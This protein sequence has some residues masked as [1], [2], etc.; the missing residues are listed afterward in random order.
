MPLLC[1]L[2]L[3]ND[4]DCLSRYNLAPEEF[5]CNQGIT[6]QL[7]LRV[8][9]LFVPPFSSPPVTPPTPHL[10]PHP[11]TCTHSSRS[12]SVVNAVTGG[13]W[14]VGG[15]AAGCGFQMPPGQ[16]N[17]AIR[18]RFAQD[19]D[20]TVAFDLALDSIH[21][22]V[23][24]QRDSWDFIHLDAY[25]HD[26][27]LVS[28]SLGVALYC[29]VLPTPQEA[30][31]VVFELVNVTRD[32]GRRRDVN[33]V[34]KGSLVHTSTPFVV[35]PMLLVRTPHIAWCGMELE[36]S[37]SQ[38]ALS[39]C[40]P[41]G[42]AFHL[43][44]AGKSL[45]RG[46]LG[47]FCRNSLLFVLWCVHGCPLNE[48]MPQGIAAENTTLN[49][50]RV[51]G[52]PGLFL[53][54]HPHPTPLCWC[55]FVLLIPTVATGANHPPLNFVPFLNAFLSPCLLLWSPLRVSNVSLLMFLFSPG[56]DGRLWGC[57][58]PRC[59]PGPL[60]HLHL[61]HDPRAPRGVCHLLEPSTGCSPL[62]ASGV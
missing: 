6:I 39:A 54:I 42:M 38:P 21:P 2:L 29:G 17:V 35:K 40:P 22:F 20:G 56:S 50:V 3:T 19:P 58:V 28:M 15:V 23:Q 1:P 51:S 57:R 7:S 18:P 46:R 49:M 33:F 24:V 41:L 10:R 8:S 59:T 32:W 25:H 61:E 16:V 53:H 9:W 26:S 47:T 62:T 13:G 12:N 4:W 36:P 52:I 60:H 30:Y 11:C 45:V 14:C 31:D 5:M 44:I 55:F 43:P 34:D 37:L 27:T 48:P